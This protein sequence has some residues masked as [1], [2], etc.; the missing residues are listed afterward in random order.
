MHKIGFSSILGYFGDLRIHKRAY[1]W[2]K[3]VS[4]PKNI[5]YG[6]IFSQKNM[7]NFNHFVSIPISKYQISVKFGFEN[8][9]PGPPG[10]DRNFFFSKK[11]CDRIFW[12]KSMF[13]LTMFKN[14]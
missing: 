3:T 6:L 5:H 14:T 2:A 4:I 12:E 10:G 7:Q 11:S 1:F 9:P 13:K 8:D